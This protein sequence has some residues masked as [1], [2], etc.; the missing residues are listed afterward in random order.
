MLAIVMGSKILPVCVIIS[1]IGLRG[2]ASYLRVVGGIDAEPDEYPYVGRMEVRYQLPEPSIASVCSAASLSANWALTA[3]YCVQTLNKL[4]SLID[5]KATQ[6]LAIITY[7]TEYDDP[8]KA[9]RFTEIISTHV[10]PSYRAYV[11]VHS[12]PRQQVTRNDI[13]LVKT[14]TMELSYGKLS[15][16][17]FRTLIGQSATAVGFGNLHADGVVASSRLLKKPLQKVKVVIKTCEP[18]YPIMPNLC[19]T[20]RCGQRASLCSGD[21][22]GP[23][24]HASGIVGVNAQGPLECGLA[25]VRRSIGLPF[26]TPVSPYIDWIRDVISKDAKHEN[27]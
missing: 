1:M 16:V 13:A 4:T 3:A 11:G 15:A 19:L 10:F 21:S 26:I 9:E 18:I 17:D 20:P 6:P 5:A 8:G 2:S 25:Q 14:K 7:K 12:G 22:G 27:L 24:I 23:V